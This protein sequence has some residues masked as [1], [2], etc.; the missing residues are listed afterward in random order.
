MVNHHN[1]LSI[2]YTEF[3]FLKN[4]IIKNDLKCGYD[5]ATAFGISVLSIGLGMKETGGKVVSMDSYI[6]E[7]HNDWSKY[8]NDDSINYD[9]DGHKVAQYLISK[10][11]IESNVKLEIGSS[12]QDVEVKLKKHFDLD[13]EKLD[14]VFIDAG[15]FTEQ[16]ITDLES[17]IKFLGDRYVIFLH[18]TILFDDRLDEYC[19]EKF[20][21]VPR[22]VMPYPDTAFMGVIENGIL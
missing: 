16:V 10:Y 21:K 22:V 14:F 13:N 19:I 15:H 6:E 5:L 1:P 20:G 7:S 18:D 2:K 11:D 8:E 4:Y 12:P 3:T 9:A 17:I